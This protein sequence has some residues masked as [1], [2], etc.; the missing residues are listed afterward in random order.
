[1]Q[2]TSIFPLGMHIDR[3]WC[4]PVI[5]YGWQIT[6][7]QIFTWNT[8]WYTAPTLDPVCPQTDPEMGG[9]GSSEKERPQGLEHHQLL[10]SH[11]NEP[12]WTQLC[13]S[14]N[15]TLIS[16]S[17]SHVICFKKKKK[18]SKALSISSELGN[19]FLQQDSFL[20]FICR[21]A[22]LPE[23]AFIPRLKDLSSCQSA[24]LAFPDLQAVLYSYNSV[25]HLQ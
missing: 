17:N 5:R 15:P 1:M 7:F 12:A 4:F 11:F 16:L 20:W 10:C 13:S 22:G 25:Q 3:N 24:W 2:I 14:V 6:Y 23:K 9:Q 21:E 8:S 19:V 18:N